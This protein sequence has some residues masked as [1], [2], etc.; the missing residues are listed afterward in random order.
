MGALPILILLAAA[1]VAGQAP[2]PD[3]ARAETPAPAGNADAW[4]RLVGILSYLEADYPL[5]VETQSEFELNEQ[6]SFI[7]DAVA[8]AQEL[9]PAGAEFVPRL[10]AV[11]EKVL[12]AADP[13]FVSRECGELAAELVKAGGLARSPKQRPDLQMGE[14]LFA[15]NCAVCHGPEG[16]AEPTEITT[17]MDPPPA[18]FH[19]PERIGALTPYKAFNTLSHGVLGTAMPSFTG[20]LTE[21]ERWS[22]AFFV[23]TLRQPGC[24]HTPPKVTL[25]RLATATDGELAADYGEQ[26]VACLRRNI[27]DLDEERALLTARTGVEDALRLAAGGDFDGAR[28]AL[29]DGYLK[30]FEIVEPR[31]SGRDA[32]L[33]RKIEEGFV[34]TRLAAE[35]RDPRFRAEANALLGLIDQARAARAD[36]QSFLS[37]FWL[38]LLILLREG[39]E[40]MVVVAALLAV[41]K[42]MHQEQHARLVHAGWISAAITGVA[43]FFFARQLIDGSRR[44]LMEGVVALIAVAMLVYA[45][46]WLNAKV[47]TRKFMGELRSKMSHAL[48]RNSR[49]GLFAI[50]FT[51]MLRESFETALFLQGLAIDSAQGTLW[52]ALAGVVVLAGLVLFT[53]RVG[54][55]LPMKTLFTGSTVLLLATAVMLLGKGLRALQETGLL[56]LAPLGRFQVDFLG[57][58]ADAWT[59]LPQLA[60]AVAPLIYWL[61]RSR[62]AAAEQPVPPPGMAEQS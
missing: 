34:D 7:E 33:V 38:S 54:F 13:D 42:K 48:G 46:L 51:A 10:E 17:P 60:L 59:L 36:A 24:D 31:L 22:L 58:Y 9:G 43:A 39:F 15:V 8:T 41:L 4:H 21:Q 50:A 27:P 53:R 32:A 35:Q 56:A 5:A 29:L 52:G 23:F 18:N 55:R 62:R 19:D 1:P 2:T 49:I 40:A 14:A 3:A 47:N 28:N 37:V 6:R 16:K 30:G 44:E 45:A 11:R 25:E 12:R 61:Y 26:E 57:I 20:A